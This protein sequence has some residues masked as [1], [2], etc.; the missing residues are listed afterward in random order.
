M[1]QRFCFAAL[2]NTRTLGLKGTELAQA[3]VWKGT[4]SQV[5]AGLAEDLTMT[6]PKGQLKK[7]AASMTMNPQL[8]API[9]NAVQRELV[10]R[11]SP[12][13]ARKVMVS[14]KAVLDEAVNAG[15]VAFN[16]ASTV[17]PERRDRSERG[18]FGNGRRARRC[19]ATAALAAANPVPASPV[20][21]RSTRC[22]RAAACPGNSPSLWAPS[23]N[24][25]C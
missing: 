5:K 4:T 15:K 9:A 22:P 12:A 20:R 14:F 25:P 8:T 21:A 10:R 11:R 6:L 2:P 1:I 17:K 3:P 19:Q 7:L 23:A 18:V 16:A 24:S 13:M